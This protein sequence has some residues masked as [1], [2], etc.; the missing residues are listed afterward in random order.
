MAQTFLFQPKHAMASRISEEGS[1]CEDTPALNCFCLKVSHVTFSTSPLAKA[2]D[3]TPLQLQGVLRYIGRISAGIFSEPYKIS[4]CVHVVTC[5]CVK[6]AHT[7]RGQ[8]TTLAV[9][10]S[11]F[12]EPESVWLGGSPGGLGWL[13]SCP[14]S[15]TFPAV[16]LLEHSTH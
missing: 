6:A 16:R 5:L 11:L 14:P 8:R 2:S 15:P 7:Y 9:P 12:F 1:S 4:V 13:V 3:K 10:P